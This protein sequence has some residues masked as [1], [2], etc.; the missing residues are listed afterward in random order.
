MPI[1][2]P[3]ESAKETTEPA[4][5]IP[6][7]GLF[8]SE[9]NKQIFQATRM[10]ERIK[11]LDTTLRDGE[12][13]PNVALSS[14]DKLKI[15]QALD[16]L[17]VDIIEAG[18]PIN[19]EGEA[20]AVKKIAG[21]GLKSEI[22]ALCRASKEDVD[23]ALAADVDSVHIFLATSK[24]HLEKQLKITKD[25]AREKAFTAVKYAKEH[26]LIAEF[27]CED[28]TRTEL[29]FLNVIHKTVEEAGVD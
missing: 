20:E 12:Q 24:V 1:Q 9:Y 16:E 17:G 13:T 22:C 10:P 8:V 14:D 21:A 11:I 6:D 2:T 15:A 19:S 28:G 29:E 18:F 23:A 27:S 5:K 25:E 26:G 7:K 3:S 4:F